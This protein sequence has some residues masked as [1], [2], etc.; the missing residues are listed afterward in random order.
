VGLPQVIG[1]TGLCSFTGRRLVERLLACEPPPLVLGLDVDVPHPL[2]DRVRFRPLDLT[3]PTADARLAE[4]LEKERCEAVVHAAFLAQPERDPRRAHE[5]EVVGSLQLMAAVSAA[6]VRKL[7]VTSTAEVYGAHADNPCF[8]TEDHP[9][10]PDPRARA[11][12]DRAEIE[13]LLR[14]FA[15]RHP[16]AV[17]TSLRP[18]W[19]AGPSVDSGVL[20]YLSQPRVATALGFDPLVQFL[21]EDDW[22]DALERVLRRDARGPYNLAGRGALPLSTLLHLAGRRSLPLP[23][24]LL[25]ARG[26]AWLRGAAAPPPGL[27]AYLRHGWVLDTKRARVE[28]GLEPLYSTKEAWLSVFVG[29]RLARYA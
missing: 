21:H 8:L 2:D 28:L 5:L 20:R 13:A 11:V 14:V 6:R 24:A 16:Q 25:E 12:G 27:G 15:A 23:Q 3:H 26:P 9:L 1:V 22:I 29:R 17:V 7:V 18:C 19:I 10:R 4:L